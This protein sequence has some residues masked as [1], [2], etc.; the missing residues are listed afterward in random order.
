MSRPIGLRIIRCLF[1]L[2]ALAE[3]AVGQRGDSTYF[4]TGTVVDESDLPIKHA[5]VVL[6]TTS[7]SRQGAALSNDEGRFAFERLSED[8]YRLQVS[9][10]G[11]RT[12]DENIG[13]FSVSRNL[14]IVLHPGKKTDE[15]PP[16]EPVV[17]ASALAVPPKARDEYR[18]A[19][20]AEKENKFE[21]ALKHA[22]EALRLHPPFAEAY[23]VKGFLLLHE[24]KSAEARAAFEKAL[25]IDPSLS[26]ALLG[27]GRIYNAESRFA[28][29]ERELLKA[30]S[31]DTPAWQINYELGRACMGLK[32]NA[33]CENYLRQA[34]A[35]S[36]SYAPVYYLLAQVLLLL[37]RP[38]EA[39]PEMETYLK[40]APEGP[41][42]DKVRDLLKR[43]KEWNSGKDEG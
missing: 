10:S 31:R 19:L 40:L 20:I 9:A 15:T 12:F 33:E 29:A 21:A 1:L 35:A 3:P 18:K 42:A 14:R 25:A 32:K 43:I 23:A 5:R 28:E 7:Y 17:S 16:G 30:R 27:L 36:P 37:D 38:L 6:S 11:Y 13:L 24:Q 41:T 4:I 22:D 2:L 26:D 39:V 34:R 8:N